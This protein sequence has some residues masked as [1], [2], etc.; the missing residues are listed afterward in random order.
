MNID[1]LKSFYATV[2]KG[3]VKSAAQYCGFSISGITR[4]ISSL[5]EEVGHKLF[6]NINQRLVLTSKGELFYERV[7][8]ILAE[9]DAAIRCLDEDDNNLFGD[10]ALN[11]SAVVTG[12]GIIDY[13]SD[14]ITRYPRLNVKIIC[15]DQDIDLVMREA[16]IAIRAAMDNSIGLVQEYLASCPVHLYA[17]K[18]YIEKYGLPKTPEDLVNHRLITHLPNDN[19]NL[20]Q[21]NWH[22]QFVDK[23]V[24]SRIAINSGV[25]VLA[26]VENGIGIGTVSE[27]ALKGAKT[28]LIRIFPHLKSPNIDLFYVY[29]EEVAVTNRV[30]LLKKHLQSVFSKQ[31]LGIVSSAS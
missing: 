21:L 10:L 25:G 23:R 9:I 20:R 7:G 5:E 3:S 13:L 6:N 22:T 17:S 19:A 26:A 16:D 30:I 24:I 2:K 31:P 29:P 28:D 14:F 12:I 15:N 4:H 8:K 11:I 27:L 18:S 1:K